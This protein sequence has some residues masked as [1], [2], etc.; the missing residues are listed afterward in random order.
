MHAYKPDV[1]VYF[2]GKKL[3]NGQ[4]YTYRYEDNYT[5]GTAYVDVTGK[6]SL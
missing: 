3:V 6:D 1:T 2:K 4:D 5:Q